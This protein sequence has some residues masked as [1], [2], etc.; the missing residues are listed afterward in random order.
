MSLYT[1]T[2]HKKNYVYFLKFNIFFVADVIRN[3]YG[4]MILKYL[5]DY[6]KNCKKCDKLTN[7]EVKKMYYVVLNSISKYNPGVYSF[8][9]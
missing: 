5:I 3:C 9:C 6:L 2:P 1:F 8:C 4:S 7:E